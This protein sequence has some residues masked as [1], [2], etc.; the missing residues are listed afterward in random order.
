MRRAAAATLSVLVA[1]GAAASAEAARPAGKGERAAM[2]AAAA[3]SA[4]GDAVSLRMGKRGRASFAP[5]GY[6]MAATV[7]A[8]RSS[9]DRRW[10]LLVV[11]ARLRSDVRKTFLLQRRPG[12]WRVSFAG[13][14][15]DEPYRLCRRSKPGVAV[16]L[17]L[18]LS[19]ATINGRCRYPRSRKALVRS[20]TASEVAS[21]RAMVEW[22]YREAEGAMVPG[23]VQPAVH[24]VFASDCS[25]DGRGDMVP[26]PAGQ[27][28]RSNPRWG[29]LSI[30]CVIGTDGFSLLESVTSLLVSRSGTSGPF[31]RVPAHTHP[32]WSAY[33]QL[34]GTD[35]RWPIPA[36]PR[37]ALDFCLPF[38]AAIQNALR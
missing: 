3:A 23:P 30:Y 32:S 21:V 16:T 36:P 18:G 15:G 25:W 37:V 24:E 34:C 1:L 38:P 35:R 4:E 10:G 13:S 12:R 33:G 19:T 7:L 29:V 11:T 27:V 6:P 31:T 22:T 26:K 20:M 2:L 17:D 14:R 9:V 28:A 5:F 8:V